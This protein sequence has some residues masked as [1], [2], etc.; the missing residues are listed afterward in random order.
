[1]LHTAAMSPQ[2][3]ANGSHTGVTGTLLLPELLSRARE[4][5]LIFC[6]VSA[7]TLGSAIVRDRFPEQ[8]L[9]DRAE[10]LVGEFEDPYLGSA[11][12]VNV[13]VCHNV[14]FYAFLAA[15]LAAS[16][17]STVA[18]PANPRR[19]LGGC[20]ALV[21]TTYPPFAPG[22]LPSTT[23]KLSSL[24]TPRMRRLRTVTRSVPMCPDIR[25]RKSTRLNS[26]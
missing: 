25:D 3:L 24:S 26:S 5:L 16:N 10:D 17:G 15:R 21:I 22:T 4:Q 20:L 13:D 12:I 14:L 11:Q 23:S 1:T 19:S 18:A 6:G 8:V 9:V 2:R 7:G